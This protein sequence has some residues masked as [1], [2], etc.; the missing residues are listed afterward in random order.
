[1]VWIIRIAIECIHKDVCTRRELTSFI[2]GTKVTKHGGWWSLLREHERNKIGEKR[3]LLS[4]SRCHHVVLTYQA[5]EAVNVLDQDLHLVKRRTQATRTRMIC[6]MSKEVGDPTCDF[7]QGC[8][9]L[10][11]AVT[12]R[13]GLCPHSEC[14]QEGSK[15]KKGKARLHAENLKKHP[16]EL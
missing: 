8:F 16:R 4:K 9:T 2:L 6:E 15:A 5:S 13:H 10:R 12:H 14:S 3:T 11:S 1:M 7:F